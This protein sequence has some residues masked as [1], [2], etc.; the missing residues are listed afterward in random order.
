MEFD[1]ARVFTPFNCDEVKVG[2]KGIVADSKPEL[3]TYV[4]RSD[5]QDLFEL[6][7]IDT[8]PN[9]SLP[10]S[11]CIEGFNTSHYE[12]FYLVEEPQESKKRPCTREELLGMLKKQGLPMLLHKEIG[13]TYNIIYTTKTMIAVVSVLDTVVTYNYEDV[14]EQL[15][16][17][18]GTSLWVY[19]V[20]PECISP[21][22]DE[23]GG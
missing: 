12:Y 20:P 4:T 14:C 5:G 16:L 15:T 2:S 7:D 8:S 1:K 10:F 19:D 21:T 22:P 13:V 23:I 11:A 9:C 18:D 6:K 3:L 17:L